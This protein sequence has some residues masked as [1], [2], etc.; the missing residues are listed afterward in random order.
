MTEVLLDQLAGVDQAMIGGRFVRE[1]LA[2]DLKPGQV[3][4][5]IIIQG[6]ASVGGQSATLRRANRIMIYGVD[7]SFWQSSP[8]VDSDLWQSDA[9]GI[10]LNSALADELGARPGDTVTLHLQKIA[11]TPRESLLGKREAS[12]IVDDLPI[13]VRAVIPATGIGRFSLQP[14]PA[15]AR[16]VFLPLHFLQAKLGQ[17]GRVNALLAREAD[18]IQGRLQQRLTLNDWGLVLHTPESK[19]EAL[20]TR[21]DRNQ[22]G[23]LTKSEYQRRVA[24]SFVRAVDTNRDGVLDREDVRK[25]FFLHHLY[26]SLQSRQMLLDA[27]T[28]K[29][30]LEAAR[31]VD[32]MTAPTLVYLANSISDGKHSI[33][34]SVVAALD[35]GEPPD[36]GPFTPPG[37]DHFDDGDLVLVDWKDSPLA[38]K[39]GEAITM[40]YFQPELEG[41]LTEAQAQFH[42]LGPVPLAGPVDDP[43][44]TPDFPGITDKLDLRDWNPPFPYDNKRVGPADEKFWNE[45][46]TTPKAFV[47][48]ATGQ[49][50]WGSRF[51]KLTSVRLAYHHAPPGQ[52][53][54]KYVREQ[55]AMMASTQAEFASALLQHLIPEE[56]GLVFNPVRAR[57]I[58]A[59]SGSTPFGW[60]FFGFSSFLIMAALLLV[61]LLFRLTLDQ[62]A[63]EIGLLFA[64][65]YRV[66]T[67]R[68]LFLAEG[69]VLAL[70]GSLVG[71]VGSVGYAWLMLRFLR[72]V[73]PGGLDEVLLQLHVGALSLLIGSGLALL[74][75][76]ITIAWAVRILGQRAPRALLNGDTSD[77]GEIQ[78]GARPRWSPW[79]V[80][81]GILGALACIVL[82][83]QLPGGEDQASTFFGSGMLLLTAGL[84][85]IWMWMALSRSKSSEE[86]VVPSV[87]R[88]GIR[89]V[90]RQA[91]RSLL[92]AGLLASATFVIVAVGSFYRNPEADF[93]E[94]KGGSGGFSLLGECDV[95]LFQ[96]LNSDRGRE[97]LNLSQQT[98]VAL[99]DVSVFGL[100][101]H[102]GEDVSCLNLYQPQKP[103]LLG[104]P[105]GL[106]ERN[107]F[108]FQAVEA[109]TAEAKANPWLVLQQPREDGSIP[110]FGEANTVEWI[111]H[112]HLGDELT[113]DDE[114]GPPIRL[115]IAG[116]LMDSVFQSELLMAESNFLALFP[117]EEG[118]SFFLI[119]APV[120][121][122]SR[123][124]SA[125]ETA[126]ADH[127]FT[128]TPSSQRLAAYLAVENTYLVTFQALGGL[129]LLLGA[130]GLAV[131]LTRT[132]WER[133]GELA[134][135]RALGFRASL[136]ERLLL[137]ENG[138]LLVLGLGVGAGA[139][140]AS[141][142]PQLIG[143]HGGLPWA[144]M[145]G[146]LAF[147][148]FFGL[149]AGALA[150]VRTLRL[151]LL[152]ALR[153]E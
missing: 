86:S 110:V 45:F 3:S 122:E 28:E 37:V 47:S 94:R 117:K 11:S 4:P 131:V 103:R 93:L 114:N 140:L 62:R 80:G 31:Q 48:L 79:V 116:L 27:V 65:G 5:A 23:K 2:R 82:G 101:L 119:D 6:A 137:V 130:L 87:S 66:R 74:I 153:R 1:E 133:R 60:L 152:P 67:V 145:L 57:G 89:N 15:V 70:A 26:I 46:R 95:P 17:Q 58:Q 134:L 81:L 97:E 90:S 44:L 151:P 12:D 144:R 109:T 52:D 51:G 36:L 120:P 22:D 143:N 96:N 29:A 108:S 32:L 88:L 42:L 38:T 148:L 100:R 83:F 142:G 132:V 147:V 138:F 107:G 121:D 8:P 77:S 7:A 112:K 33:P 63:P 9:D 102:H 35:S 21:L 56:G 150:A 16:N 64:L 135:F 41:K 106:I 75:S 111:L 76:M 123:V 40:S 55:S 105:A 49:K 25:Y 99:A 139:A 84:A 69:A 115:H 10:V 104:L 113:I 124:K 68:T 149:A 126:L 54:A 136:L 20:F 71:L 127:G 18:G 59:S 24:E 85:A 19:T 91:T 146:F 50:L 30:A 98:R 125:L 43:D 72:A 128:V 73:W 13:K 129:G 34:Y 61:G 92:T 118:Y 14:S 141:V 39:P 53:I 78:I